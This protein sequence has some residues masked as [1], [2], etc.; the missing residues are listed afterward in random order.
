MVNNVNVTIE[1]HHSFFNVDVGLLIVKF[2]SI[3]LVSLSK[4]PD[5]LRKT[6]ETNE[7]H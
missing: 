3:M 4:Y 5:F 1:K 6:H 7:R 2:K